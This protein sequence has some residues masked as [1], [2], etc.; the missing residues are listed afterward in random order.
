MSS[1]TFSLDR[2]YAQALDAEDPL[3]SFRERF[4]LPKAGK[5]TALYFTGNS[6][7]CQPKGVKAYVEAELQDWAQLG[8]EGHFHAKS[9]WLP[10]HEQL[11]GPMAE[12][13]GAKP[14]EVVMMNG[15][16]VNLHLMMASFFKPQGRRRKILIEADAFPSDLYA[17]QSQLRWHGLHPTEDLLLLHPRDGEHSIHTE[18]ILNVIE[19]WGADISMSLLGGVNYYTGQ[20]FDMSAITKAAQEQGIKVG[21][22]LAHAAGNVPLELHEWGVDFACWC[23]Y[24]Y[25]NGGPGGVAGCFIHEQHHKNP[26]LNRLA[27][28]W[29]H[30]KET[31]F[32]MGPQFLPIPTAEGWQLSNAPVLSMAALRAS[33][34][35]FQE[36]GMGSIRAKSIKLTT[37][38]LQLLEKRR[39]LPRFTVITPKESRH[40]GAQLSLL[41][42]EHGQQLFDYLTAQGVICDWREP[43]VIRVA[44][45]PLYNRFQDLWEFVELMAKF[46]R[47]ISQPTSA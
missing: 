47:D 19:T 22:D 38:L 18:D 40:R 6:L 36:A 1:L 7:G 13:V 37:Y 29:G 5:K 25:L 26:Q 9:P 14:S 12:I 3:S 11:S 39:D 21:W 43:N 30:D 23:S 34:D 46:Q 41:T 33:L 17:I 31:R 42:D 28:W 45:V 16:T 8:V 10:Y 32:E 15:L 4:F 20:W 2:T 24:K 35:L 27:G 44:P